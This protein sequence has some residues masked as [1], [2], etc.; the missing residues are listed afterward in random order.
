[1]EQCSNNQGYYEDV[2][3][4]SELDIKAMATSNYTDFISR[5]GCSDILHLNG[6]LSDWYD[7]YKN[8]ITDESNNVFKVPLLFT[9][10]GTKPLTSI[11]MSRRYIDYYDAS[12]K[13]D[14]IIVIGY[15]FN[16]DDGHINTLLRSLIDDEDK[17]I[18]V[19]DYNC[20]DVGQRKKEIL[21]S[22][23]CDKKSNIHVVSVDAER[24]VD[25]KNWLGAVVEKM[26]E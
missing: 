20:N 12:K 7:P 10:S 8:E 11:S 1:V 19:L 5:T 15:G 3:D 22:L 4:S 23:R 24:L 14:V 9:Q 2:K 16:A 6:K 13:S 21:R 26:H 18:V 17:K 25:G